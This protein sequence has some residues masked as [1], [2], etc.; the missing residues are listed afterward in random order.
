[1]TAANYTTIEH[2]ETWASQRG[3]SLGDLA[4]AWLLA[5]PAVSSVISGV[6]HLDQL[7]QNARAAD[8]ILESAEIE[9]INKILQAPE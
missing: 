3:H 7:L 5:R 2:L 9:E 1:M 4:H 8:W 6:T